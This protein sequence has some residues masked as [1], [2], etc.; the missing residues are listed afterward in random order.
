M[1]K[2]IGI[3]EEY[4]HFDSDII[5]Y[6]NSAFSTLTQLGVGP[7]EG[8]SITDASTTWNDYLPEGPLLS[9]VQSYIVKRV[10]LLFDSTALT[11]AVSEVLKSEI[12]ADEWRI[13]VEVESPTT[14]N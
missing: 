11:S 5:V 12:A 10:R 2:L 6:I 8:F 13:N 4:E 14:G 7:G 3:T 1:K 9:L